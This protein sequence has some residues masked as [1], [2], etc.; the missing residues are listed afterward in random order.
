MK[1]FLGGTVNQSKWRHKVMEQLRIDYF[2]PVVDDWNDAAYE[3]ELSERR[4]CDYLLYVITPKMTGYYAV[5]EVTDDSYH[6]PDRTIYCYLSE[7]GEDTFS[8]DQILEFEQLGEVVKKN[9]GAWFRNLDEVVSFLNSSIIKEDSEEVYYDGFVTFGRRES[10]GFAHSIVNRLNESGFNI[11]VDLN[12]IPLIIDN[13]EYIYSTILKSDN[14]IYII[15]SNA[16]RSEYCKKELDFAIKNNKRIIPIY[17]RDIDN[18]KD[19]LDAIVAKKRIIKAEKPDDVPYLVTCIKEKLEADR[20]YVHKHTLYLF[21]AKKWRYNGESQADLLFGAER[22]DA[23][24]WLNTS[25]SEQIPSNDHID[26]IRASKNLSVFMLPLLWLSKKTKNITKNKLFD[27][28]TFIISFGNPIAM[29]DQL[30]YLLFSDNPARYEGV[31]IPMWILFI[32]IQFSF[33]LVG[34]KTKNLGV[35]ISMVLSIIICVFVISIAL[36]N[37]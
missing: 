36:S 17:H 30:R 20:D 34:I 8:E 32:I 16:I 26:F 22:K 27:K 15:S 35:F 31:S 5:A 18:S 33:M 1:V 28:L 10:H 37:T 14:F 13:E 11:F 25:S 7:D 29:A 9:G 21:Q 4:F 24:N 3:R 2:D 6:R 19:K 12:D 23:I